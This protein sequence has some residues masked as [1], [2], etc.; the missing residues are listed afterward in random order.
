[1]H[2]ALYLSLTHTHTH[3]LSLA[4]R[5]GITSYSS[6]RRNLKTLSL[7]QL[8]MY[9]ITML[10]SVPG[11]AHDWLSSPQPS[12]SYRKP[13]MREGLSSFLAILCVSRSMSFVVRVRV[14]SCMWMCLWECIVGGQERVFGICPNVPVCRWGGAGRRLCVYLTSRCGVTLTSRHYVRVPGTGC[15]RKAN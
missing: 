13:Q 5:G 2:P 1:M 6:G 15:D 11:T 12:A 10:G 14:R 9:G 3:S 8:T 4:W 7:S